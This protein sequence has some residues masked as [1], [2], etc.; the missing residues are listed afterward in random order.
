VLVQKAGVAGDHKKDT[1]QSL[2]AFFQT[3]TRP[4]G[5][6]IV[7]LSSITGLTLVQ[8]IILDLFCSF[9]LPPQTKLNDGSVSRDS[10][11]RTR[12]RKRPRKQAWLD[13]KT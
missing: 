11:Q 5:S 6:E 9:F 1:K 2:V 10:R 7:E 3:N 12:L 13:Y 8:S 4:S